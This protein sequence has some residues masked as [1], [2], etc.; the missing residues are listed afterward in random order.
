MH[1]VEAMGAAEEISGRL[2]R[3]AD[4]GELGNAVRLDVELEAGLDDRAGDG[5][6]PATRT[7]RRYG[8]LVIAMGVAER[9]LRQRRMVEFGL[10]DIGH[11]YDTTLRNGVTL[12]ASRCSPMARA[13]KRA[14]IGVPS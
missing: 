9:I 3:A 5:I 2:G 12:S 8:S 7:Q 10:G 1:G 14:V 11:G 13:M 4:A 6:V